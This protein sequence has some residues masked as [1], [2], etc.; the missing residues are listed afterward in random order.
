MDAKEQLRRYLEQRREMGERE[1]ILDGMSVEEVMRIV[2][3]SAAGAK[4][5][6]SAS[7]R[8]VEPREPSATSS[9]RADDVPADSSDWRA[10]LRAAGNESSRATPLPRPGAADAPP[11]PSAPLPTR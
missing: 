10:V 8:S 7:P 1:L 9:A 6:G 2:G 4:D 5:T 11:R 3:A